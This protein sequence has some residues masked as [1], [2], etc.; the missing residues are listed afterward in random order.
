MFLLVYRK[1]AKRCLNDLRDHKAA[2]DHSVVSSDC[3]RYVLN[4]TNWG[5]GASMVP[6]PS[7]LSF[8]VSIK[9]TKTSACNSAAGLVHGGFS[10]LTFFRTHDTCRT[11]RALEDDLHRE[12][13][14][15]PLSKQKIKSFSQ[16]CSFLPY[17]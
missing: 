6:L 3:I 8:F 10:L 2:L 13:V 4:Y 11:K 12:F 16:C 14:F 17:S 15:L 7:S 1:S 5:G 9:S